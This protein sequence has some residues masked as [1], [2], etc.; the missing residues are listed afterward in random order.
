MPAALSKRTLK[1]LPPITSGTY[2]DRFAKLLVP[3]E[4]FLDTRKI[5]QRICAR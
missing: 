1:K 3:R 5:K 2:G 4:S